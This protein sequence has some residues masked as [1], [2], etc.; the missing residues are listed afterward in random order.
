MSVYY[1]CNNGNTHESTALFW[2]SSGTYNASIV[3]CA[4]IMP[5]F[6]ILIGASIK[7]N[8]N[9]NFET[10][11]IL[12]S[13]VQCSGNESRLIECPHSSGGNGSVATLTCFESSRK[14]N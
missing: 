2:N 1:Q 8:S 3:A 13:N 14:S 11:P 5:F 7:L 6:Y 12:M 10:A 4:Y 9:Y